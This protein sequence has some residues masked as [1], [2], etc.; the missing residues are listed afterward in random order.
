MRELFLEKELEEKM[1]NFSRR[2]KSIIF[3]KISN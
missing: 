2:T 1:K 3:S